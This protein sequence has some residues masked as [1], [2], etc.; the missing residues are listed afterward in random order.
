[1]AAD[2]APRKVTRKSHQNALAA[3]GLR[4]WAEREVHEV[5][6]V[7]GLRI[8]GDDGDAGY[9]E[10]SPMFALPMSRLARAGAGGGAGDGVDLA[11]RRANQTKSYFAMF[12]LCSDSW[13]ARFAPITDDPDAV[14]DAENRTLVQLAWPCPLRPIADVRSAAGD[15]QKR[16]VRR[17]GGVKEGRMS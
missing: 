15:A 3:A 4:G 13:I 1:M 17:D 11:C 5:H 16:T 12:Y 6:D 8:C 14:G 2:C 7:P 9:R 10:R